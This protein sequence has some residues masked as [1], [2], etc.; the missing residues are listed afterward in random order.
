MLKLA[1]TRL[2]DG[3]WFIASAE[4]NKDPILAVLQRTLPRSGL[5]LEIGSGTGQHVI[6]FATAVPEVVWQPSDPDATLR[7][8]IRRRV[9]DAGLSNVHE[10]IDLELCRFPWPVARADAVVCINVIHVAPWSATQALMA[11]A[12]DVL[13]PGGVLFLYGPYRRYGGH[14]APSN[15]SFDAQ[16]R[17]TEATWGLRDLETVVDLASERGLDLAE[18]VGMPANNF[19]VLFRKHQSR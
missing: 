18:V 7:E 11:G 6:H 5:V 2:D 17:A 14:T 16:L 15:E 3:R 19:S 1:G 12:A 13:A 10:P 8:S 4:R 9:A